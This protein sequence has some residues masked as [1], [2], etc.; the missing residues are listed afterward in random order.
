M[1]DALMLMIYVLPKMLRA[2]IA[3]VTEIECPGG[4]LSDEFIRNNHCPIPA[5]A[6]YRS[7]D[8]GASLEPLL[9]P[10]G[11]AEKAPLAFSIV[12]F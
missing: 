7:G 6:T 1:F 8:R 9:P 3:P 2:K 4:R 5:R 11:G 12:E 10:P